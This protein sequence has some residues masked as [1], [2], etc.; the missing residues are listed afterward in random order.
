MGIEE[1]ETQVNGPENIFTKLCIYSLYIPITAPLPH[2]LLV[3][4][5]Q[6]PPLNTSSPLLRRRESPPCNIKLQQDILYH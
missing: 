1:K 5:S 3:P 6:T 4:P 2:L